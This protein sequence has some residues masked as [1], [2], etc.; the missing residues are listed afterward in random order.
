MIANSAER[1]GLALDLLTH[2]LTPYVEQELEGTF[3]DSWRQIV[4]QSFRSDRAGTVDEP[5]HW[6]AQLMLSVMWDQWNAVFRRQLGIL[7][8][9]YVCELRDARNRWAH[10]AEFTFD[11]L[12]RV[13]DNVERMLR[14]CGATDAAETAATE[15]QTLLR[16]EVTRWEQAQRQQR[17]AGRR[18]LIDIAAYVGCTLAIFG[19]L[20][21][22]LGPQRGT[23]ILGGSLV[24]LCAF[25]VWQR[26]RQPATPVG[27][28]E[29]SRC[30]RIVY[31]EEC[32]Y[33]AANRIAVTTRSTGRETPRQRPGITPETESS[34]ELTATAG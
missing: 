29:C 23:W 22:L 2:T 3:A 1:V 13:W 12:Y 31:T 25:L 11:D 4:R 14:A 34:G 15:K 20:W 30:R 6:D 24:P 18:W 26:L 8:R 5:L 16:G 19:T 17:Q 27:I 9:S 10:Q 33:C 28:H 32:P 7:E 21:S